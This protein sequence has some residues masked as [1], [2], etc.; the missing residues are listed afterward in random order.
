MRLTV[1]PVATSSSYS[2]KSSFAT[3]IEK[4]KS[5]KAAKTQEMSC[6]TERG[7]LKPVQRTG[8]VTTRVRF[9]SATGSACGL[10]VFVASRS[11]SISSG[12]STSIWKARGD[13]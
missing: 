6:V 7:Q 4:L 1:S 11:L 3:V 2:P 10:C 8:C 9:L 12:P 13:G 5:M